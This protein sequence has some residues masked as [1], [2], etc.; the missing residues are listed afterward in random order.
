[1]MA[2]PFFDGSFFSGGFFAD[3]SFTKGGATWGAY[4]RGRNEEDVRKSRRKFGIPQEAA[5]VVERVAKRQAE[6]LSLDAHQRLEELERELEI[7]G[8]E[9]QS[10]YLAYLNEQRQ[11]F[12]DAEIKERL[13][14][15]LEARDIQAIM[16]LA[17]AAI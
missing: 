6:D 4:P 9:W 17:S 16:L 8:V 7:A 11:Q 10:A 5:E 1:M 15:E 3:L 12:M 13:R 14:L 2:S